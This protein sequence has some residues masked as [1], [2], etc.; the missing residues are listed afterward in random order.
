MTISK[1]KNQKLKTKNSF[2][3][4]FTLIELLVAVTIF[5]GL[6]ILAIGAFARSAISAEKTDAL[7][8]KTEAARAVMDQVSNDFRY[9]YAN[10]YTIDS[11]ANSLSLTIKFPDATYSKKI[12][13]YA[14]DT[15]QVAEQRCN[16]DPVN[17]QLPSNFTALLGSAYDVVSPTV[18][19]PI[20]SGANSTATTQGYLSL[21]LTIKA[22]D[23]GATITDVDHCSVDPGVC[24]QLKTTL[25]TENYQR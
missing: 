8:S 16:T 22:K 10:N 5:S 18:A 7:R 11:S 6:I 15:I 12:Y 19:R 14:N 13:R 17:C 2:K 25:T 24:Y 4:G 23:S 9:V 20:F 21:D 1:T 3:K